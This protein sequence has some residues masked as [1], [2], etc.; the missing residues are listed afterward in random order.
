MA[1]TGS[2]SFP[3][4]GAAP[5]TAAS[6]ATATV[7]FDLATRGYTITVGGRSQTFLPSDMD[8]AQSTDVL[9]VYVRRNGDTVD[10]LTITKP[11]TSGR[12]TYQYVGSG[13]WQRTVKGSNAISGNF[14]AFAYGV[15]TPAGAVPR[16]GRAE[17]A[18]DLIGVE[19]VRDNVIGITGQGTT[20]V[21][22][23]SGGIVTHGTAIG[24]ITKDRALFSSEALLSSSANSFT[25]NFRL[26]D[27]GVFSGQIDGKLYGP[28]A[29]EIGA[30]FSAR[31][32]D[33]RVVVGALTGRGG[34]VTTSNSTVTTPTANSFYDNDAAT[35]RTTL[36]GSTGQ[37]NGTETFSN[38]SAALTP[39]VVNYDATTRA[40]TLIAP[41]RS[42]YFAVSGIRDSFDSPNRN[43]YFYSGILPSTQ[44]VQGKR[45][46]AFGNAASG[47]GTSYILTDTAFGIRTADA[48]LPRTGSA[49][50]NI[51]LYGSAADAD[52]PNLTDFGGR[53]TLMANLATGAIT[54]TGTLDWR[55]DYYISGRAVRTGTGNFELAATLSS[56]VNAFGGTM[57]FS[58]FGAYTGTL[59]GRF[60][61][62][63]G[64]E[65]GAAFAAADGAGGHATGVL[66]GIR[67]VSITATVPTLAGLPQATMLTGV[68]TGDT[69]SSN[70][71]SNPY[72]QYD[73]T[74]R[75]YGFY[76]DNASSSAGIAYRFG[77]NQL[78]AARSDATFTAYDT[79]GPAGQFNATDRVSV[80]LF[81]AN[82]AN[83]R[84]ALSYTSFAEISK[85]RQFGSSTLTS[86]DYV[87]FGV[88]PPR[89]Q[90]PRTGSASYTGIAYGYGEGG[91]G[92]Y[93]LDG[94]AALSADFAAG[95][96]TSQLTLNAR[97]TTTGAVAALAPIG[98]AGSIYNGSTLTGSTGEFV[99]NFYGPNA[100]EFGAAFSRRVTDATI[101]IVSL[102]GVA[103]GKKN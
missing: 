68:T 77:P 76:P 33:G 72:V 20:Q 75:T 85:T 4:S 32:S 43:S 38:G 17:Y 9:A 49:G 65:V 3:T 5:T 13:F 35:L 57:K 21:D 89:A 84:L 37:N 100:A 86:L 81:N 66:T 14:D 30:A 31:N 101:G 27:F 8:A 71:S 10:S 47:G 29:Q 39:L 2:A 87:V 24:A 7:R 92:T 69:I 70:K 1:A 97:N 23:A 94:T 102:R 51:A 16:T 18:I 53:G 62:P 44:Y 64:E 74:T 80:K 61:G 91:S 45:W 96:F 19:T 15:T 41:D 58:G 26:E 46:Y 78:V 48:A 59:N 103:V 93:S 67:D 83:P 25:G 34:A 88:V 79:T 42:Q 12:F 6:Q 95:N 73:P 40:Y 50:Y 28:A 11:G 36:V 22:F 90:T 55:E 82:A 56:S 98:Y 63:T 52:L 99:G 54:A 60:Y